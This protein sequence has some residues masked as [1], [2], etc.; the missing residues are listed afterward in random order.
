MIRFFYHLGTISLATNKR[1]E[2]P[3]GRT[4]AR[5]QER[6]QRAVPTSSAWPGS[7]TSLAP[8]ETQGDCG[9]VDEEDHLVEHDVVEDRLLAGGH[10]ALLHLLV[11]QTH[12]EE[13]HTGIIF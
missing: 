4:D 13:D 8:P 7:A 1:R 2:A 3:G 10:V 5:G 9:D 6:A 11:E 12:L